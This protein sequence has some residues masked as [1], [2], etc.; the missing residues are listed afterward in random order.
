FFVVLVSALFQGWT[1]APLARVL[2]LQRPPEPE[3]PVTLEITSLRHVEG[4]IVDYFIGPDSPVAGK[5]VRE[6]ALPEGAVI[7]LTARGG[8]LIPPQGSTRIRPQDHVIVVL[9]SGARPL[10]DRVFSR[11]GP[12]EALPTD[13]EFPLRPSTRVVELERAYGILLD[14]PS[15]STLEDAIRSRL[16]GKPAMAGRLFPFGPVALR[17]RE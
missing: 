14:A 10:V 4:D 9:G 15:E 2:G 7:A 11:G 12:S 6:L 5:L 16:N 13:I 8:Q 17:I 3:A 1:M